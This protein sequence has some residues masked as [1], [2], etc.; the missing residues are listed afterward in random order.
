MKFSQKIFD[1]MVKKDLHTIASKLVKES[2]MKK[3]SR[4]KGITETDKIN[5]KKTYERMVKG[6]LANNPHMTMREAYDKVMRSRMFTSRN[7]IAIENMRRTA[8]KFGYNIKSKSY[9]KYN[10]AVDGY[11]VIGGQYAGRTLVRMQDP[12]KPGSEVWVL[13]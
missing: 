8:K 10:P 5:A 9:L 1:K 7:E 12:M 4:S 11:D 3:D 13:V 6:K 2:A